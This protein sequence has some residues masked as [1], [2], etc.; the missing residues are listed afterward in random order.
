MGREREGWDAGNG[1]EGAKMA[2]YDRTDIA[3][4]TPI[5]MLQAKSKFK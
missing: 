3:T 1:R 5:A 4:L 2:D